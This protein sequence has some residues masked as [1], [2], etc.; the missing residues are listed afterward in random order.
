MHLGEAFGR[1]ILE[2]FTLLK[3][4]FN[5]VLCSAELEAAFQLC[6]FFLSLSYQSLT[7]LW[8]GGKW[9]LNNKQYFMQKNKKKINLTSK[10]CNNKNALSYQTPTSFVG[11]RVSTRFYRGYVACFWQ[12]QA[13]EIVVLMALIDWDKIPDHFF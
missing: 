9:I 8:K 12:T 10:N 4:L 1:S 11:R 13:A 7:F 3:W 5:I 2:M 6:W